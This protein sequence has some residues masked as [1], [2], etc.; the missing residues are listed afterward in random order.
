[1]KRFWLMVAL[2]LCLCLVSSM[3]RGQEKANDSTF[4][5]CVDSTV[6]IRRASGRFTSFGSGVV[7]KETD[8]HYVV[9]TNHHVA[10]GRG[11]A[12]TIDVF[13]WGFHV[14]SVQ[15]RTQES[16]FR[17]G[18][19]K[20]IAILHLDKSKLAGEMPIKPLS[21][22]G[23]STLKKNDRILTSGSS[24][25]RWTRTRV[26][27]VLKVERGLIYYLPQSIGG[28]SGGPV[29]SADGKKVVGITAWAIKD[30]QGRWVGLAMTADRVD[31]IMS[32]RVTGNDFHLPKGAVPIT[33]I[34]T[35]LPKGA[36]PRNQD[37]I[38]RGNRCVP[39]PVQ[40][41][42]KADEPDYSHV[43]R[44]APALTWNQENGCPG[45]VCPIQEDRPAWRKPGSSPW[46]KDSPK[47]PVRPNDKPDSL[48]EQW[49]DRFNNVD[50]KLDGLDS[51]VRSRVDSMAANLRAKIDDR[52]DRFESRLEG[53][54]TVDTAKQRFSRLEARQEAWFRSQEQRLRNQELRQQKRAEAA[55]R[56]AEQRFE[57]AERRRELIASVFDWPIWKWMRRL[58]L[59]IVVAVIWYAP[60][61][62]F[63]WSRLWPINFARKAIETGKMVWKEQAKQ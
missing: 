49:R 62:L 42:P 32:G 15:S 14:A 10:G 18:Q 5:D 37:W 54:E 9:I 35:L 46:L 19:S 53:F 40:V 2:C 8:R 29:F 36:V 28:D 59:L 3:C 39:C 38:C 11:T 12:N 21:E 31:D 22:Y 58:F 57:R 23:E 7:I 52:F 25:G 6:R 34:S 55:E 45:G 56:R 47:D 16:W 51:T 41:Q 43:P 27:H 50:R 17:Q 30:N 24:D 26:G 60:V 48:R 4:Q 61:Y 44:S 1:M 33:K 13:N 63:G 20:D